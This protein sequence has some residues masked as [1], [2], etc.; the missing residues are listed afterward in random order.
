MSIKGFKERYCTEHLVSAAQHLFSFI[1][2]IILQISFGNPPL[3]HSQA[4]DLGGI[5]ATCDF[6]EPPVRFQL[7]NLFL[8]AGYWVGDKGVTKKK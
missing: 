6:Q 2:V 5:D 7:S 8:L 3:H 4:C 1:L